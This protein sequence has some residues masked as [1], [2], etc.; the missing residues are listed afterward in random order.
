MNGAKLG[1]EALKIDHSR[2][3]EILGSYVDG[4]HPS[5]PALA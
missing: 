3:I 1:G 5:K 2:M 4:E